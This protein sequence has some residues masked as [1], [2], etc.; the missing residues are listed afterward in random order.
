MP[1]VLK[2]YNETPSKQASQKLL[3]T[4]LFDILFLLNIT[5]LLQKILL[6]VFVIGGF[7]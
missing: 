1:Q 5:L 6:I 7:Y 2:V 3:A 4:E